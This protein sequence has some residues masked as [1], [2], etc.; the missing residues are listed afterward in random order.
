FRHAIYKGLSSRTVLAL[1]FPNFRQIHDIQLR[2]IPSSLCSLIEHPF[3][4]LQRTPFRKT[5]MDQPNLPGED[6]NEALDSPVRYLEAVLRSRTGL[7]IGSNIRFIPFSYL[8]ILVPIEDLIDTLSVRQRLLIVIYFLEIDTHLFRLRNVPNARNQVLIEPPTDRLQSE[9]DEAHRELILINPERYTDFHAGLMNE[10][11]EGME[12]LLQHLVN[13]NG[14]ELSSDNPATDPCPI[15]Q[16]DYLPADSIIILHCHITHRFHRRCI[17]TWLILNLH[18]PICRAAVGIPRVTARRALAPERMA[19]G[20]HLNLNKRIVAMAVE[21]SRGEP[22]RPGPAGRAEIAPEYTASYKTMDQPILPGEEHNVPMDEPLEYLEAVIR[23]GAGVLLET[24]YKLSNPQTVLQAEADEAL[25]ALIITDP[26]RY[27]DFHVE[28]MNDYLTLLIHSDDP[29]DRAEGIEVLLHHLVRINVSELGTDNPDIGACSICQDEYIPGDNIIVLRCH[30]SHKFHRGCIEPNLPGEEE[31]IGTEAGE[32]HLAGDLPASNPLDDPLEYLR[33]L[34]LAGTHSQFLQ[35]RYL[36]VL[37]PIQDILDTLPDRQL[38]LII[39]SF[40]EMDAHIILLRDG[41]AFMTDRR[42]EPLS[43]RLQ[44]EADENLQDFI[45]TYPERYMTFHYQVLNEYTT[46][47]IQYGAPEE[48]SQAMD[49]LLQLLVNVDGSELG[50]DNSAIDACSICQDEYLPADNIIVLPCHTSHHFH[51]RCIRT[52][53][54]LNLHCPICRATPN[55][56]GEDSNV[57]IA[58]I[59]AYLQDQISSGAVTLIGDHVQLLPYSCYLGILVPIN[60]LIGTLDIFDISSFSAWTPAFF[61]SDIICKTEYPL[62]QSLTTLTPKLWRPS[63][64]SL[65]NEYFTLLM[66]S[67]D[68]EDRLGEWMSC[69]NTLST[70][71]DRNWVITRAL[72]LARSA[73]MTTPPPMTSYCIETW[74]HR[75]LNCPNCRAP[76]QIAQAPVRQDS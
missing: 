41:P 20:G 21:P 73:R 16:D 18:C 40:V 34:R 10:Q 1:K 2:K 54:L 29:E 33:A 65:M 68:P 50:S 17:E 53:L 30:A 63:S 55:L 70:S 62:I 47:L 42:I 74:L 35:S 71:T 38:L 59:I 15:C 8:Q 3:A 46:L 5:T 19:C 61:A 6:H 36:E 45:R 58:D 67:D 60:D 66:H 75:H 52:W 23:S 26:Q 9:L 76:V 43:E 57:A 31:P 44:A 14:L 22:V 11:A 13:T 7:G 32:E 72:M 28:L 51:R 64:R 39:V 12:I 25:R 56:P 37:V 49:V 48:K 4:K 24:K 27:T 69:W